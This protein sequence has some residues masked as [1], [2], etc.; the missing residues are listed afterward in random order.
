MLKKILVVS[1]LHLDPINTNRTQELIE[2][3]EKFKKT[4]PMKRLGEP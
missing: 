2:N 1:I 4:L 3:V